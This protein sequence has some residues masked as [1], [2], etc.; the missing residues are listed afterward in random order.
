MK[1]WIDILTP[2]QLLFFEPMA[3]KLQKRRAVVCTARRYRELSSLA[4]MRQFKLRLVGKHGGKDTGAKLRASIQRMKGLQLLVEKE[5]PDLTISFCSPEA[6]RISYG[7]G[8]KHIGFTDSPHATAAMKLCTPLVQKLLIPSII[9]KSE[10]V[11]FGIREKNIVRYNAIDAFVTA[12]RSVPKKQKNPFAGN[13]KTVLVRMEEEEA[14]YI[15]KKSPSYSIIESMSKNTDA[16]IVVLG[17]YSEQ[18]KKIKRRFGD[19]IKVL[20]KSYDGKALLMNSDLFVGSGGTMTAESALLGVPT[21]SYNAVPN[22]VEEYLIKKKVV[23]REENPVKIARL[24]NKILMDDKGA[25]LRKSRELTR[26]M[27]DPYPVLVKTMELLK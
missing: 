13:K 21:I 11:Q 5:R 18:I 4:K 27:K 17:R 15:S 22:L 8:I 24:A 25:Y 16:E 3:E 7:M 1:I 14:A 26:Q 12:R 2:K 10:F 6:A 23:S 20:V 9:P 19:R